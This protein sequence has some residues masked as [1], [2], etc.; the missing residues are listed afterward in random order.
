MQWLSDFFEFE[1]LNSHYCKLD[2]SWKRHAANSVASSILIET[3]SLRQLSGR[4][5][6]GVIGLEA[7]APAPRT[8]PASEA[9]HTRPGQLITPGPGL[10]LATASQFNELFS[11]APALAA[12]DKSWH[13]WSQPGGCSPLLYRAVFV[14]CT[15]ALC[16][17]ALPSCGL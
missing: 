6:A 5:Q 14:I 2:S 1:F 8:V 7:S 3:W 11:L 4:L 15:V 12:A 13:V 9:D 10:G 17:G 16:T